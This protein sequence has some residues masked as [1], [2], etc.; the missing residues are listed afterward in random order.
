MKTSA[1]CGHVKVYWIPKGTEKDDEVQK[2][3]DEAAAPLRREMTALRVVGMVP[4]IRFY[5][6]T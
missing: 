1:D 5:K 6:S 4:P 2:L 3:L